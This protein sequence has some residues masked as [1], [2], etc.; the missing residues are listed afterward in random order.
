MR[1]EN[2]RV[3]WIDVLNIVACM[4]VVLLHCTNGQVHGFNGHASFEWALG[5]FTHSTFLWPVNVFFMLSGLTLM[6]KSVRGGV[7]TFYKRRLKRLLI[8]VVTWNVVYTILA[9]VSEMKHASIM[10][11]PMCIVEKFLSFEYNGFMWFFVPLIVIYL[12]MPFLALF[13]LNAQRNILK[14]YIIISAVLNCIAPL[15]GDFSSR[16]AFSDIYLF[17]A[18]F[19]P[20]VVAGYYIGSFEIDVKAKKILYASAL[21]CI[22]LMIVGTAFL[23]FNMPS[24]Y[25]YFIQYINFPCTIISFAV[26]LLFK[27]TDWKRM[28]EKWNVSVDVIMRLSSL[29]LGIYLVQMLGF[30]IIDHIPYICINPILKF[31]VMYTGCV[32]AVWS[33]KRIPILRKIV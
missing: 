16:M 4:G 31:I 24:H 13:A 11:S 12:S 2:S 32:F 23:Q 25:K 3:L 29:S 8:P 10:D 26:F 27:E 14:A 21:L 30:M 15:Q 6:R 9:L 7:K 1:N 20:Y 33:M 5:L 22:P 17:G 18:R 19:L 28:L